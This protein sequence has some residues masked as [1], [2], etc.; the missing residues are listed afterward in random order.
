MSI[1][2][3]WCEK[4]VH[5]YYV[6]RKMQIIPFTFMIFDH[7]FVC[8]VLLSATLISFVVLQYWICTGQNNKTLANLLTIHGSNSYQDISAKSL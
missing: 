1:A 2:W 6:L 3:N 7:I 8:G 4:I 5:L